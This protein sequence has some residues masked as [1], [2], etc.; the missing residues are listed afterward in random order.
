MKH[1]RDSQTNSTGK[2]SKITTS[3]SSNS[4]DPS[5]TAQTLTNILSGSWNTSPLGASYVNQLLNDFQSAYNCPACGVK[6]GELHLRT[7]MP[8]NVGAWWTGPAATPGM[9]LI[10]VTDGDTRLMAPG[11]LKCSLPILTSKGRAPAKPEKRKV[12][13]SRDGRAIHAECL[14]D[15]ANQ[16]TA[17]IQAIS[18]EFEARRR[19]LIGE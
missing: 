8:S 14:L 6:P 7:C 12:F 10:E 13:L 19:A 4:V 5:S 2:I 18:E 15:L 17:P 16:V 11:C 1:S 9:V 3:N